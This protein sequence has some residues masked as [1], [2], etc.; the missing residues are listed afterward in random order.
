MSSCHT[1]FGKV[2][3]FQDMLVTCISTITRSGCY[4]EEYVC[5]AGKSVTGTD[6]K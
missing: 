3:L 2:P 1:L 6:V 5:E 4:S